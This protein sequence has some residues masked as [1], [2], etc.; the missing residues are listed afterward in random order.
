MDKEIIRRIVKLERWKDELRLPEIG[1]DESALRLKFREFSAHLPGI[2]HFVDTGLISSNTSTTSLND[3]G[4]RPRNLSITSVVLEV[5]NYVQYASFNGS[6]S[7]NATLAA[8]S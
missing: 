3:A 4:G 5:D 6:A 1:N 7:I 8:G 2:I